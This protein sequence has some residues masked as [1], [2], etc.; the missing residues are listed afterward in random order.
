MNFAR[1]SA[2]FVGLLLAVRA[3]G[4][5]VP[6]V[7]R[8]VREALLSAA[9]SG[10][11]SRIAVREGESVTQGQA[12][13]ELDRRQEELEVARRKLLWE[14]PAEIRAAEA[15]RDTT[16]TD[17]EATRTLFESTKSVSREELARKQLEFELASAEL[18]RA[19]MNKER[20]KIEYDMAV[21][22]LERRTIRAPF[23]GRVTEIK[24]KEG[25]GC[26]VRQPLIGLADIRE[27]EFSAN[28]EAR[29]LALFEIGRA[30]ELLLDTG[31]A[32]PSLQPATIS[33]VA[34][35]VD[36]A[37]GLGALKATFNN[38]GERIRPGIPARLRVGPLPTPRP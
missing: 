3:A 2:F 28:V 13:I 18:L 4:Q 33:Y 10:I 32:E 23:D 35:V 37:S 5:D 36:R 1:I 27:L 6:G 25:E 24:I 17:F 19:Q 14:N 22:A 34:P 30:V 15:R 38:E 16:R 21:E 26:E 31:A 7:T 9:A 12:L 8:P 11:V 29:V 20:E